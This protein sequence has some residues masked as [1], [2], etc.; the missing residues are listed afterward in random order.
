MLRALDECAAV[1]A[2]CGFPLPPPLVAFLY[3]AVT[4]KGSNLTS[5]MYRDLKKGAPVEVDN[6]LGDLLEH[7]HSHHV[8]TPL[9]QA[10]CVRLRVYQNSRQNSMPAP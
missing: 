10:G 5:S 2:A 3:Q 6:I 7:G 1:S 9:L 8:D 4:A